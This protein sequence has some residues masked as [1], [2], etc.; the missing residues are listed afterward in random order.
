MI[1]EAPHS[2]SALLARLRDLALVEIDSLLAH[3]GDQLAV[4]LAAYIEDLEDALGTARRRMREL[5]RSADRPEAL[6][7]IEMPSERRARDA[8]ELAMPATAR[9]LREQTDACRMLMQLGEG[10][11]RVL[12]RLVE[13]D[14]RKAALGQGG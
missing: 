6:A 2:D 4:L 3:A 14:R 9:K 7:F 1:A 11:S 5:A 8:N 12:P 10:V 13:A